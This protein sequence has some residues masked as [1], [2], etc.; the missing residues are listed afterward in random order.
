M[1]A[2]RSLPALAAVCVLTGCAPLGLACSAV[3]YSSV[4]HVVLDDPRSGL[5]LELCDGEGCT[6]GPIEG[7]V[8]IGATEEPIPTGVFELAGS[9]TGGWTA[10][11]SGGQPTLGY[12]LTDA[13]GAVVG[14]GHVDVDWVRIDGTQQCGGNREARV[15]LAG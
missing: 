6:P 3:G 11:L 7:P 2:F 8:K 12:R 9:S 4:V 15:T 1:R 5:L 13:T 14:E 10:H